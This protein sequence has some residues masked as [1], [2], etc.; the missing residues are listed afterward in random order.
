MT[1]DG[2]ARTF[3]RSDLATGARS[4]RWVLFVTMV[5]VAASAF[6]TTLLSASLPDI[7]ADLHTSTS[8]ISWVQAAPSIAFAVGMPF[9]G[10]LG[11]LY[12]HRRTFVLGFTAMT[13][14]ALVTAVAWNAGSLIGIRTVAQLAGAATSTAAFGLIASVF[15]RD[16]RARAIGLY[17]AVLAMSPVIAVVAGGPIIER[18]GWRWLFIFQAVPATVAIIVGYIILPDT[19]R[20]TGTRF[21]VLGAVTLTGGITTT[22]LAVNRGNPWG[23]THPVVVGGFVIGPLL[24]ALFVRIENRTDSPLVPM[25]LLRRREFSLPVVTNGL[26]QL[27]YM[28]GFTIAPFMLSRLFGYKTYKTALIIAIRP[29]AFSIAAWI[30]GRQGRRF[31]VRVFQ[32]SGNAVVALSSV[33]TAFGAW[34]RS[35][36]LLMIGLVLAG[37]GVG[38]GRP[39]NAVS[40]TNSVHESD[41]GIATG[42]LNM[43]STIGSAVGVTVMLAIVG[44]QFDG[45]PFAHASLVAAAVGVLSV[46]TGAIVS[47]R[48]AR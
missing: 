47:S 39:S 26:V 30:A 4:Q 1:T 29:V 34:H 27:S 2:T 3:R 17:T 21:D 8:V 9:F 6:P 28:G 33:I 14:G 24:L 38:Y 16:D 42:V 19:P 5:G 46:L 10:K 32:I 40:V 7:A 41:V 18:I 35:L 31:D 48:P 22:L 15:E 12:G 37:A 13:I 45:A 36:P 44:D 11:D 43:V 23:W 20:K 25:G